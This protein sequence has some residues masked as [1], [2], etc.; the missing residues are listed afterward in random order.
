MN[1]R[2]VLRY[3]WLKVKQR[4]DEGWSDFQARE[5][6]LR[7]NADVHNITPEQLIAAFEETAGDQRGGIDRGENQGG[8]GEV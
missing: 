6:A 4:K 8:R 1:P 3:Q 7:K 5:M 2:M